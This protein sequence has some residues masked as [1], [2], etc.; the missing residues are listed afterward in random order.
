MRDILQELPDSEEEEEEYEEQDQGGEEEGTNG[1]TT[2]DM[3]NERLRKMD[4]Q[5][6]GRSGKGK[7]CTG[8][9][10]KIWFIL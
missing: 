1:L 10:I 5:E 6:R 8:S 3:R 4:E 2:D 7:I 9:E